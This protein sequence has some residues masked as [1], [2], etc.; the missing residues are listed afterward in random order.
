MQQQPP[1]GFQPPT[2]TPIQRP[3]RTQSA[4]QRIM[5]QRAVNR[6]TIVGIAAIVIAIS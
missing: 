5:L 1:G 4:I 2:Q 6:A 3:S